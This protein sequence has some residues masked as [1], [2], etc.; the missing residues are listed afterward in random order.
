MRINASMNMKVSTIMV[1]G[2]AVV[3]VP[4]FVTVC[5]SYQAEE[6]AAVLARLAEPPERFF[7]SLN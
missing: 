5:S 2:I 7:V 6:S 4:A 1:K 3:M